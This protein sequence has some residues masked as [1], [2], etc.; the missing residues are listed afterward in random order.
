MAWNISKILE[1]L[2]IT[3]SICFSSILPNFLGHFFFG[4][5]SQWLPLHNE[6]HSNNP[7]YTM[8]SPIEIIML[9]KNVS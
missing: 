7:E 1:K 5:Q 6:N 2:S 8:S 4:T 9:E 3:P